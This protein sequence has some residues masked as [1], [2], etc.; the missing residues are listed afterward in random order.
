MDLQGVTS[1]DTGI[2]A[3]GPLNAAGTLSYRAMVGAGLEFGHESGDGWKWMGALNW[4]PSP[5][6]T[7][8]LYADY[9]RRPGPS[10]RRTVQIFA[11]YKT[12]TLRWG[13][14]YSNQDR[15]D[16]PRLEL[17]SAFV[18]GRLGKKHP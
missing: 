17:A 10:D 4:K 6:W 8:D 2:S 7:F 5:R 1:R 9:E 3:K 15:Q 12:N 16:D 14:Q 13:L 18:V 11:G